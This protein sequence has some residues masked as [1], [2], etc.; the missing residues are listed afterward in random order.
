MLRLEQYLSLFLMILFSFLQLD[1]RSA[2]SIRKAPGDST[3]TQVQHNRIKD[4][5]SFYAPDS[6]H[7]EFLKASADS[8]F[9]YAKYLDFLANF[10][11]TNKY[12]VVPLE[13]FRKT[14]NR[15]K[16]IIGLRHDVDLDL[17]IAHRLSM[18]ENN[19]A[20]RSSYYIQRHII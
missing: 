13:K 11:D 6:I 3:K 17:K 15:S 8:N 1:C 4:S 5:Q 7:S 16:I 14:F 20:V 2:E 12:I 9:T 10:G 18:V 19:I